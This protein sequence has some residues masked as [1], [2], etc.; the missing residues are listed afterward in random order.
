MNNGG[1]GNSG[2]PKDYIDHPVRSAQENSFANLVGEDALGRKLERVGELKAQKKYVGVFYSA[3]LG[4]H[5]EAQKGAYNITYLEST[6]EGRA[7]L[8]D[9]SS[10][11]K[12]SPVGEFH[13]WGEPLYGYYNMKDP[14]VVARHVELFI[15]AGLDY[16]CMDMTNGVIYNDAIRNV[17]DTLLKFQNQGFEVPK[18]MFYTNSHSGKTVDTLYNNFYVTTKYNTL[19]MSFDGNKPA[20]IGTSKYNDKAS[21]ITS[22]VNTEADSSNWYTNQLSSRNPPHRDNCYSL[23]SI[24]NAC[25][26]R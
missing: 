20:I 2:W 17:L 14:W 22:Y 8:A 23:W 13:F 3:W 24:L 26:K 25:W 5:P 19:W 1:K 12:L 6:P 11:N 15:Q 4:Q 21:D 7:A 10:G 9:L 16:I 18:V